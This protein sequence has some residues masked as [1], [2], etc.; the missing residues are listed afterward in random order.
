MFLQREYKYSLCFFVVNISYLIFLNI[1]VLILI[2]GRIIIDIR[3]QTTIMTGIRTLTLKE[4]LIRIQ[5][6]RHPRSSDPFN[7]VT[8]YIKWVTTSWTQYHMA[9]GVSFLTRIY[10]LHIYDYIL[11]KHIFLLKVLRA[12]SQIPAAFWLA[13]F[14]GLYYQ[15]V[16]NQ[17]TRPYIGR[18]KKRPC[19][20]FHRSSFISKKIIL[21]S[22]FIK[23]MII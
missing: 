22:G 8:Y 2:R 20:V 7:T 10:S 13:L 17:K 19:F 21:L 14:M 3:V 1:Q 6:T 11:C 5:S 15:L 18:R 23:C 4:I 9:S 12:P 16:M